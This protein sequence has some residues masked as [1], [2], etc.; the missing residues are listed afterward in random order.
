MALP[1]PVASPARIVNAKA[2]DTPDMVGLPM[3]CSDQPAGRTGSDASML[4]PC[5]VVSP[6]RGS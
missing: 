3:P 6:R 5:R 4:A 2:S 1:M